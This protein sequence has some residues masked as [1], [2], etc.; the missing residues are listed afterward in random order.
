MYNKNRS[1]QVNIIRTLKN[2]QKILQ[3]KT[4]AVQKSTKKFLK[5]FLKKERSLKELEKN[6]KFRFI[7]SN[8]IEEI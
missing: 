6:F 7:T 1:Q 8:K 3:R 4:K 5:V 2:K